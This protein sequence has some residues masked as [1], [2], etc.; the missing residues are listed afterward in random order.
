[1]NEKKYFEMHLLLEYTYERIIDT[2]FEIWNS[3]CK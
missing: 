3:W 1:M 2:I